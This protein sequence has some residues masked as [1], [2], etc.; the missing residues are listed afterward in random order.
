MLERKSQEKKFLDENVTR[1]QFMKISGKALVGVTL[2]ASMLSLFGCTTR[3][4]DRGQVRTLALHEGLLI[5]N[6]GLCVG[7]VRCESNCTVTHDGA[8]SSYH[9]RIK[10]TRNLMS[11]K[12][13]IGMYVDLESG[14]DFFPDT[15]RQ[16]R[17]APCM[18]R[19]PFNAIYEDRGVKKINADACVGCELCVPACP[20]DMITI[21]ADTRKAVKCVNCG[22]CVEGCPSGA[23]KFVTWSA[24][25][26]AAQAQWQG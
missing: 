21:K 4:V 26:A 8:A 14:W 17:P 15:C 23:L 6:E 2:S 10:V 3:Q 9:S 12:N 1:R 11:N 24:V 18:T 16:C 25:Q 22:V 20:W 13:R 19:C 5:V 7:C